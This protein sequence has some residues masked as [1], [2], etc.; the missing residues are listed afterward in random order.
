[1]QEFLTALCLVLI[2][3]GLM[4]FASPKSWQETLRQVSEMSPRA[5]R[6]IGGSAMLLG[7]VGLQ[8]VRS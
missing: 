4:P 2:I 1:M 3:E 5:I 8:I 7:V 6:V